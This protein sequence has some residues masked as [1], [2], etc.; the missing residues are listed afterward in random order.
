MPWRRSVKILIAFGL[1][2]AIVVLG[3]FALVILRTTSV[4]D[5]QVSGIQFGSQAWSG[6]ITITGDTTVLGRLKVQPGTTVRFAVGDDQGGGSELPPDGFNDHDPSR[7]I[8]YE[9][10]HA[11]LTVL[12]TLT[13]VGTPEAPITFTSSAATPALADWQGIGFFGNGSRFEHVVV[14]WSR[15]GITPLNWRFSRHQDSVLRNSVVRHTLWGCVSGGDSSMHI[16]ANEISDCGHEGVDQQDGSMT[17]RDNMIT[18]SQGGIVVLA[19]SPTIEGNRFIDV[20]VG[21]PVV[22]V[23]PGA[24]PRVGE[25]EVVRYA[26]PGSM[27]WTYQG[28]SYCMG[29]GSC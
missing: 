20:G 24:T 14:E 3:G 18:R 9:R 11:D 28:F 8:A 6:T 4:A 26:Q 13:A 19:G 16:I 21:P 29:L 12:G 1:T 22:V 5:A 25:N 10:T 15:N 27:K 17:I 23:A 2:V 7:L